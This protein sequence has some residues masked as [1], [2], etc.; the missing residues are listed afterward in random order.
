[1]CYSAEQIVHWRNDNQGQQKQ[2]ERT[3]DDGD[4]ETFR[5]MCHDL[6]T[7]Y[8]LQT[9]SFRLDQLPCRPL[10]QLTTE[11]IWPVDQLTTSDVFL[12]IPLV[13]CWQPLVA[14]MATIFPFPLVSL[15]PPPQ[16]LGYS[17]VTPPI[18]PHFN[19]V[20]SSLFTL[21]PYLSDFFSTLLWIYQYPSIV[22]LLPSNVSV[23]NL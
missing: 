23:K 1:M 15:Q 12:P 9:S 7:D 5:L 6:M 13:E 22:F 19:Y 16:P 14:L 3:I 8:V 18:W 4:D 17:L 2:G 11:P 10:C 20:A 21:L